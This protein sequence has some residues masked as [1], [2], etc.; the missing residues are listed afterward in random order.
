[1]E[2][3]I[4][5]LFQKYINQQ[6]SQ[7]EFEEVFAILKSG[8]YPSE[9]QKVIDDEAEDVLSS[10]KESE[11]SVQEVNA[12]YAGI[13][14]RLKSGKQVQKLWPRI[15][16]VAAAVSLI[17]F[18]LYFLQYRNDQINTGTTSS[19][20][21]DVKPGKVGA[22]LT[23]A[24]GKKIRLN[25]AGSGELANEAGVMITKTTAGQLIY[26]MEG[27]GVAS[28][29]INVLTTAKGETYKV[30]LPDGSLVWLNAASAL[31][32]PASFANL[33][34]RHVELVG[35][36]YF[37]IKK[38][39][40]HPFLVQSSGQTVKVLGTRFNI[41]SYLNE[42]ATATTLLEGSIILVSGG[43]SIRLS[44]KEKM[45]VSKE[46]MRME[47][48]VNVDNVMD[49]Q[50]DDFNFE[51]IKL[52]AALRKLER[53]YNIEFVLDNSISDEMEAGGWISRKNN[54]SVVLKL[55]SKSGQVK[56]RIDQNKVYV[57]RS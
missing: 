12:I 26:E 57:S 29:K 42:P 48:N 40:K 55:I 4:I 51:G 33:K 22:T 37:E 54:L 24:N 27:T 21:Q 14:A 2:K 32:Y 5:T 49:W 39:K 56:F 44:P 23:L 41:N 28:D 9:W 17:V 15:V 20:V 18:G 6:C 8:A 47:K 11:L 30:R 45:L 36:A 1:M 10:G 52:K 13:A 35:E 34:E 38:D 25:D 31:K 53:W 7:E 3:Q 50:N 46:G 19:Y 16:G 43:K